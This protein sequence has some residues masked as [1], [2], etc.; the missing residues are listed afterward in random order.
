MSV[1]PERMYAEQAYR[2]GA[3]GYL[4][5]S[6]LPSEFME[7][8]RRILGGG[9]YV[10]PQYA[11]TFVGELSAARRKESP[12]LSDRELAVLRLIAS[13]LTLTEIGRELKL[14]VKTVS[15]HKSR[16][17]EKLGLRTNADLYS[18]AF[19]KDSPRKA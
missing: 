16:L 8:V 4:E 15:T 6:S 12:G 18:Y 9:V 1:Y 11:E 5:K 14:S 17:M 19:D 7:A 3:K 2:A 10:S 13:G